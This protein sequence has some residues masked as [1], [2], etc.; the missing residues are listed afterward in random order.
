[1]NPSRLSRREFIH[2]TS[3]GAAVA[4]TARGL[5]AAKQSRT[6]WKIIAFS[7]PFTHLNFDDTADL[8]SDVG[9]DGIECPVR[10]SSTHIQP[11]RV[12]EDLPKMVEALKKRG[13]EVA[14][15]TTDITGVG[16]PAEQILGTAAKLGI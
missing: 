6:R 10:K 12:E 5:E 14:M 7:K 3:L 1:M 8:I 16:R 2:T 9:W 4:L 11:E 13:R 15:I